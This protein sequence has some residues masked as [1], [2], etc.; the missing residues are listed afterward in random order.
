MNGGVVRLLDDGGRRR[1]D[2]TTALS[3]TG[4]HFRSVISRLFDCAHGGVSHEHGSVTFCRSNRLLFPCGLSSNRG[5][6]LIVLLAMLM[7]SG[8]RYMLFV[9]RPR[10]SL[11]VR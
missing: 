8:T 1:H 9:S 10:T 11:R 5:R 2:G 6:V 4:H 7:R 3:V